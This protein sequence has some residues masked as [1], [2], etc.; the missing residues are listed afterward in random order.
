MNTKEWWLKEQIRMGPGAYPIVVK[1]LSL[2]DWASWDVE[3][4]I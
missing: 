1:G 3:G 2:P 4:S